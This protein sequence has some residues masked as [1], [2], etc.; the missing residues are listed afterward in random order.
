L[1]IAQEIG[2]QRKNGELDKTAGK[3]RKRG[4]LGL[5]SESTSEWLELK[6]NECHSMIVARWMAHHVK[7]R[8]CSTSASCHTNDYPLW[9]S[10]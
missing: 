1:R 2:E 8:L 6:K 7:R 10:N 4:P 3:K 9:K 5:E